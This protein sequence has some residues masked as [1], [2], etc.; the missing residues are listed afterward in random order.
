M[1]ILA[2]YCF[3]F[4]FPFLKGKI[5]RKHFIHSKF[6]CIPDFI[7]IQSLCNFID[8][9]AESTIPVLTIAQ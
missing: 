4:I 1:Q 2:L 8:L 3:K 7:R 5:G 6:L 9:S